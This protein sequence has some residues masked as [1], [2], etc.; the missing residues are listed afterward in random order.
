MITNRY[1]MG[2]LVFAICLCCSCKERKHQNLVLSK[3]EFN[4]GIVKHGD[5]CSDCVTLYNT[6]NMDLHIKRVNGDC[7]CTTLAIDRR[8][9]VPGD[10]TKLHFSL[11]TKE[12]EGDIENF[13]II[14]ANTDS[15]VH[16]V[17]LLATI[18]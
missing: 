7:R 15:V 3:Y 9:I 17:R 6:G 13:I 8:T 12:K 1:S 18:K 16:Y 10:S 4:F 2:V 11:D 5:I 14:E